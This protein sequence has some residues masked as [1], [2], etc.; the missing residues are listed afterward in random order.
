MRERKLGQGKLP[1]LGH[2]AFLVSP[3]ESDGIHQ[4]H[5]TDKQMDR[6]GSFISVYEI[7]AHGGAHKYGNTKAGRIKRA[8]HLVNSGLV[9]QLV[10]V[11]VHGIGG[12]G[13]EEER[14][15]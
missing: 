2:L 3:V 10:V 11:A 9:V 15:E 5:E 8:T 1:V 4:C 14:Q 7:N 13:Q 12:S 6:I